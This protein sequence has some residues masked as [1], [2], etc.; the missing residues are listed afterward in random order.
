[1]KPDG[2][3]PPTDELRADDSLRVLAQRAL[4]LAY[5][6][7]ERGGQ[8][9]GRVAARAAREGDAAALSVA[10]RAQA[11]AA[12]ERDDLAA[13]ERHLRRSAAVATK[14]GLTELAGAALLTRV[15]VLYLSG[16]PAAALRTADRAAALVTGHDLA[17]LELQRANVHMWQGDREPA[18]RG[19]AAALVSFRREGDVGWQAAVHANRGLLHLNDSALP[20]AIRDLREAER[21]RLEVGNRRGVANVRQH[22]GLAAGRAGD[23]PMALSWFAKA[24]QVLDE[25]GI[26]DPLALLDRIEVLLSARLVAEARSTAESAVEQ[27]GARRM[28]FYLS[29]ARLRLGEVA[30]LQ[31]E[32]TEAARVLAAARRGFSRQGQHDWVALCDHLL[33]RAGQDGR[34]RAAAAYARRVADRLDGVGWRLPA[35]DAR[36]TAA[37]FALDAGRPH[38]AVADLER[39]G[40][41]T[42]AARSSSAPGPGTPPRCSGS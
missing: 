18:L 22:L 4:E 31:G 1:M 10:A 3:V 32:L 7:A 36:L 33:L 2:T 28:R 26:A 29:H 24:D 23:L 9:A 30:L 14:H 35:I 25:L 6:D 19:F 12:R 20:A 17:V 27:I 11:I 39:C 13:A 42:A 38:E 37:R 15:S 41:P 8:L 5:T 34:R 21:L 16:R 40:S